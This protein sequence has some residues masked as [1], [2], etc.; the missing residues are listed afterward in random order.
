MQHELYLQMQNADVPQTAI[1]VFHELANS[2]LVYCTLSRVYRSDS[3]AVS[4]SDTIVVSDLQ[5][6]LTTHFTYAVNVY[7][8]II[9]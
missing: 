5:S 3:I 4:Q 7:M 1:A 2:C 6:T 9:L 8:R